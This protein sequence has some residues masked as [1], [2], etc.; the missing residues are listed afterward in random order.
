VPA[1]AISFA[2]APIAG[3]NF[4]AHKPAR[5]RETFKR[6]AFICSIAMAV[7]TAVCQ[8]NPELLVRAFASDVE[9]VRVGALFLRIVSWNFVAQGLIFSCSN[10]FQGLGNTLPSIV[11]SATRLIT[12]AVPAIWL[13][14]RSYFRLEYVFYWSIFTTGLQAVTSLVLLR[15]QLRAR[16]GP[17][18]IAPAPILETAARM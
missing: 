7:Q 18:E 6:T 4:G 9:V 5:V 13:S 10:M 17:F 16:L 8:W 2:A 3:Q 12:Y 14:T 15:N 1:L 11:S